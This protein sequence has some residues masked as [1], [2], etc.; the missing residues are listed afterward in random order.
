[1]VRALG[2]P[3]KPEDAYFKNPN[4]GTLRLR[5]EAADSAV[6]AAVEVRRRLRLNKEP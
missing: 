4:C 6:E 5:L 2:L 1:M 3:L